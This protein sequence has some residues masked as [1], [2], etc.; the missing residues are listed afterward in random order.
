MPVIYIDVLF[1]INFA[2]NLLVLYVV[3]RITSTPHRTLRFL[4]AAGI[5][6]LYGV[7]ALVYC[8]SVWLLAGT[9][10]LALYLMTALG[11]G[12]QPPRRMLQLM[13]LFAGISL[14]LGA[15]IAWLYRLLAQMLP[16]PDSTAISSNKVWVFILLALL[17]T[18]L[19]RLSSRLL[20][21]T[22]R[23]RYVEARVGLS[24]KEAHMHLFVD[25]G[26]G[27]R[28]PISGRPVIIVDRLKLS[29]LVQPQDL[30]LLSHPHRDFQGLSLPVQRRVRLIPYRT[31]QGEHMMIGI[32]PDYTKIH[33]NKQT[34]DV[35]AIIGISSKDQCFEESDGLIPAS[36]VG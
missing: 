22:A 32:L 5:G 19:I 11:Y 17:S 7:W 13:L 1:L 30:Q 23:S 2:M 33:E 34:K 36:L 10:S 20:S 4:S 6:A 15:L 24:G 16:A 28:E 14:M 9:V 8:R 25:T 27:V 35:D 29:G 21:G 18:G 26:N 3:A 12:R 31:V